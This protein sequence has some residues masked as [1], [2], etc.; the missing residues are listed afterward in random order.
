MPFSITEV[1]AKQAVTGQNMRYVLGFGM[2]G[3]IVSFIIIAV[4]YGLSFQP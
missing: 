2:V 4:Y 1:D 3:V